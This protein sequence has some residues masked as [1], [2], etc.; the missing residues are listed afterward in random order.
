MKP[1]RS[2]RVSRGTGAGSKLGARTGRAGGTSMAMATGRITLCTGRCSGRAVGICSGS[3]SGMTDRGGIG[4]G[5][6]SG[7]RRPCGRVHRPQRG[8][9]PRRGDH[10]RRPLMGLQ[11]ARQ[12]FQCGGGRIGVG[13]ELGGRI[14]RRSDRRD[15]GFLVRLRTCRVGQSRLGQRCPQPRAQRLPTR[16]LWMR[17]VRQ[18]RLG[19]RR[20]EPGMQ[21]WRAGRLDEAWLGRGQFGQGQPGQRCVRWGFRRLRNYRLG[22]GQFGHR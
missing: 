7:T 12:V 5:R 11:H 19:E 15:G 2:K 9:L 10:R 21:R 8:V 18:S 17:G 13:S 1:R 20:L 16:R 22:Q 4:M 14:E 3:P 6:E